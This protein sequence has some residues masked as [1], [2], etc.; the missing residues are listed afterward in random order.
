LGGGGGGGG[1][2][3]PAG[4]GGGGGGAGDASPSLSAFEYSD[5]LDAGTMLVILDFDESSDT[6]EGSSET[7]SLLTSSKYLSNTTYFDY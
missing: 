1:G 3:L 6:F 4:G 2:I 7:S 5:T